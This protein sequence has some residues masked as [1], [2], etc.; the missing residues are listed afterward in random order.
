MV[1]VFGINK[2]VGRCYRSSKNHA[3]GVVISSSEKM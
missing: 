2:L 3:F 1:L